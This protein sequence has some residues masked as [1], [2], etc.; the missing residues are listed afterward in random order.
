MNKF[1]LHGKRGCPAVP[2]NASQTVFYFDDGVPV[3]LGCPAASLSFFLSSFLPSCLPSFLRATGPSGKLRLLTT[4]SKYCI[5][6]GLRS[7]PG[8]AATRSISYIKKTPH[9]EISAQFSFYTVA[10]P[11]LLFPGS[12]INSSW[13]S[14]SL[15]LSPSA[16]EQQL[17]R[18]GIPYE[19]KQTSPDPA[20]DVR[21]SLQATRTVAD[22]P[23]LQA[24]V[25]DSPTLQAEVADSPTLQAEVADSQTPGRS[26]ADVGS[27]NTLQAKLTSVQPTLSRQS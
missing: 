6:Q 5:Q 11:R 18:P 25:A 17:K 21:P 15:S 16:V 9:D 22:S 23:T 4:G 12:S 26:R 7:Y 19:Q 24:E 14:L 1:K 3:T 8:M 13:F 2:P 20:N 27:T 10:S